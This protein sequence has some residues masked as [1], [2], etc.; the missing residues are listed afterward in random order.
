[1]I[2]GTIISQ[3]SKKVVSTKQMTRMWIKEDKEKGVFKIKASTPDKKKITLAKY[4]N[5]YA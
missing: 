2:Y 1:M 4:K 5:R 3:S